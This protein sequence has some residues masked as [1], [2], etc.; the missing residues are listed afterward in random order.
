MTTDD[1]RHGPGQTL[2]KNTSRQFVADSIQKYKGP[3]GEPGDAEKGIK[4]F[5]SHPNRNKVLADHATNLS[6]D[7]CASSVHHVCCS[8]W[9][10]VL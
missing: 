8:A 7:K 9:S 1:H 5:A 4:H 3:A 10:L 2:A 6:A